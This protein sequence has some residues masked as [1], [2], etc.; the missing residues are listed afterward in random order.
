MS[1]PVM[2]IQVDNELDIRGVTCPITFVKSKLTL[3]KMESGQVLRVLI[4]YPPSAENVP[5]SL[6][7][8]GHEI[9]SITETEGPLWTLLV[10][11][12]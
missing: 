7:M 12:A 6:D 9:L 1:E 10:K 11:K 3:E 4:D 2:D 5:R 8:E